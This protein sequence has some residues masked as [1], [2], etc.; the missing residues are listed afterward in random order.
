MK[1]ILGISALAISVLALG[2]TQASAGD[3]LSR[4]QLLE[5]VSGQPYELK[6][7]IPSVGE[8]TSW[9]FVDPS[10]TVYGKNSRGDSNQ[11]SWKVNDDGEYCVSW[12]NTRWVG[13]C[14]SFEKTG[15]NAYTRNASVR[16][17][18]VFF[19]GEGD[20]YNVKPKD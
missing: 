19:P 18:F 2:A 10:G 13:G 4:D 14:A 17:S 11:G 1:R 5:V 20:K 12:R 6:L 8:I 15:E 7:T 9:G 16:E 3:R